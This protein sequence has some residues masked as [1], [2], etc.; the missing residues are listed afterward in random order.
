MDLITLKVKY[1]D[2]DM[3]KLTHIDR[4]DWIDLRVREVILS[5]P[6]NDFPLFD[7]KYEKHYYH[8]G[9]P[10]SPFTSVKIM[11]GIAMEIPQGYEVH[12]R[13]R[14]STFKHTG[15]VQVNSVAVIDN[16]YCGDNDEWFVPMFALKSG[17]RVQRYERI[18]QFRLFEKMPKV[19]FETVKSLTGKDRGGYGSTGR[20]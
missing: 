10:I 15:L 19:S 4:G 5:G 11:L 2:P 6:D 1:F 14:S 17:R 3:P 20:L 13:P 16:S 8:K 12:I 7:N 9:Y 18:C